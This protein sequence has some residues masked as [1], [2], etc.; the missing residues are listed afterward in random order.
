MFKLTQQYTNNCFKTI[1]QI[2]NS[3]FLLINSDYHPLLL[4]YYGG[5]EFF[6]E[7]LNFKVLSWAL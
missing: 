4:V 6:F 2:Y 1:M 3:P 5:A 7:I